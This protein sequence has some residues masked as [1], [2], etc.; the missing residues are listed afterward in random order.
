MSAARDA[1]G[2][3]VASLSSMARTNCDECGARIVWMRPAELANRVAPADLGRLEAIMTGVGDVV[4]A[5][6]CPA[7]GNWGVI[8]SGAWHWTW[9]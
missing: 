2:R 8:E 3:P 5:W 9:T 7:C 4:D 1:F 6:H